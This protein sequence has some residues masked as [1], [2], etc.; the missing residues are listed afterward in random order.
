M[1]S[2]KLVESH[3][4]AR[5]GARAGPAVLWIALAVAGLVAFHWDGLVSLA[6]AW[7]LPEYS[8]GPLIP[9]IAAWL[10]LRE[11]RNRP[12]APDRGSRWPGLAVVALGLGMGLTGNLAQIP[13]IITY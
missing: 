8:H 4:P 13:D 7:A 5:A 6:D 1:S 3:L 12:L 10:M 11:L 2:S 9:L